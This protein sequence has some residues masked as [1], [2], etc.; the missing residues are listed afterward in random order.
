[1]HQCVDRLSMGVGHLGNPAEREFTILCLR[2]LAK[3]LQLR[4]VGG[5]LKA[6]CVISRL[7]FAGLHVIESK[8]REEKI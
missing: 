5:R 1:V 8:I 7:L 3:R 2:V 6:D 4:K